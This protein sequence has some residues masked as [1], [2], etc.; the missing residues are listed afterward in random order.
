MTSAATEVNEQDTHRG[1][2]VGLLSRISQNRTILALVLMAIPLIIY[3]PVSHFHF[4][5]YDDNEYFNYHVQGG[6]TWENIR[7]AFTTLFYEYWHP[8][9]WLAHM[10]DYRLFG[11]NP[12]GHHMTDLLLHCINALLL[13]I[14]LEALTG[15][16]TRSFVVAMLFAV[17]PLNVESVVWIAEKKTLLC[18]LFLFLAMAAYASY[19]RHPGIWRYLAVLGLFICGLM[20]KP[21]IVT[22][23]FLLLLLDYWP[24]QRF[25]LGEKAFAPA[26]PPGADSK[27]ADP[28]KSLW[29]TLAWLSLE[30]IPFFLLSGLIVAV[31]FYAQKTN[32]ALHTTEYG[33][34]VRLEN[35]AIS[36][37][38]YISKTFWP[39][40][41]AIFYP[42]PG[43]SIS[44]RQ[45]L[46]AF[47]FL[48]MVAAFVI[49]KK[50]RKYLAV[51]WFAFLGILVPVI[52]LVQAGIQSMANRY[53]YTSI[54]GLFIIVVWG[55]GDLLTR[56][57]AWIKTSVALLAITVFTALAID[58]RQQ[59]A[60]WYDGISL[61][62]HA[63]AVTPANYT[64]YSLLAQAL[65]ASGRTDEALAEFELYRNLHPEDAR[66]QYNVAAALWRRGRLQEA[67]EG[68][69]HTLTLTQNPYILAH[70]HYQ[71]G[72]VLLKQ[73]DA[74]SAEQQYRKALE[75]NPSE[76]DAHMQLA[77]I[78]EQNGNMEEAI[79]H[80]LE[81]TKMEVPV[82]YIDLGQIYE[83]QGRLTDALAA[84]QQALRLAPGSK[85]ALEAIAAVE[86][87]LHPH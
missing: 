10:L 30:K 32:G 27:P 35:V 22:F 74:N 18:T 68:F 12:A 25:R 81:C 47:L 70:T 48:L 84:Y 23:P 71:L 56:A 46:F 51:G 83:K 42:H 61:F 49:W 66:A 73:G 45:A 13:F 5:N 3:S 63:V 55:T 87:K 26:E 77:L 54:I 78:L 39:V 82:A 65:E 34:A 75:L 62:S 60:Y 58:T 86:Q 85:P 38:S 14:A 53:A 8:I 59:L 2:I 17:H 16:R 57:S 40:R 11:L 72:N 31:T 76:S 28:R 4:V 20:S 41:L 33:L 43:D 44:V 1:S 80:L 50:D 79:F 69:Q 6:F 29:Q 36:Y 52:G 21:M 15:S 24:L 9:T 7:W 37:V 67:A 64:S 19:A